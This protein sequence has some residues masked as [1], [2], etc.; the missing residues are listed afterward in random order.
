M[1]DLVV[2]QISER[3][4]CF[5]LK[6]TDCNLASVFPPVGPLLI[7]HSRA[8]PAHCYVS[9]LKLEM[10]WL[11]QLSLVLSCHLESGQSNNVGGSHICCSTM[12]EEQAS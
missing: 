11:M 5:L 8:Q 3:F 7:K 10:H 1:I 4:E 2:L 6:E 9:F 12:G